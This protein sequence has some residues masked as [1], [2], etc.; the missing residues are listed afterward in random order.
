MK[1]TLM[2][3]LVGVIVSCVCHTTVERSKDIVVLEMSHQ[4]TLNIGLQYHGIKQVFYSAEHGYYF[5]R[6]G[7]RCKFYNDGFKQYLK[8]RK[9]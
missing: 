6:E 4:E 1:L 8:Q 2:F 9:G 5:L 7:N 3:L